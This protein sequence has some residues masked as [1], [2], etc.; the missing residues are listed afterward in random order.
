MP[1]TT[2]IPPRFNMA[3]YYIG[4]AA[5]AN[6]DRVALTVVTD[7]DA[8]LSVA[9]RWTFGEL[10]TMIRRIAAGLLAEGLAPGDRLL[11]RRPNGSD[12]A[13]VF[14]RAIAA[15]IV[16]IPASPQLTSKEAGFLTENSGAAVM[17]ATED[18]VAGAHRCIDGDVLKRIKA[19][20]PLADC[21][22]TAAE[23]PALLIYTSGTSPQPKGVLHAP[24]SVW[25][26]VRSMPTGMGSPA[27][28]SFCTPGRQ[29]HRGVVP[30]PGA[31]GDANAI[32][33]LAATHLSAYKCPR[34]IIFDGA[35]PR[36]ANGKVLRRELTQAETA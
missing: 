19:A 14:F 34:Q 6:G 2:T 27:T 3:R 15:G 12:Y 29:G 22:D 33:A 23:D 9:E 21:A 25:G 8:P 13:L 17:A 31:K 24:R 30:R 36:S 7:V 4:R 16:P 11:I 18:A 1:V 20:P 26:G 35:L 10:G 32:L 28:T 5:A